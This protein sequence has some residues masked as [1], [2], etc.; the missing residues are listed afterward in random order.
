MKQVAFIFKKEKKKLW[1]DKVK[2]IVIN[3]SDFWFDG[4]YLNT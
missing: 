1:V 3:I 2:L 4:D